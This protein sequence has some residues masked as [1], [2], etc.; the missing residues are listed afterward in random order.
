MQIKTKRLLTG[1]GCALVLVK[2]SVALAQSTEINHSNSVEPSVGSSVGTL[3]EVVV[4]GVRASLASALDLKRNRYE[5]VDSVVADDIT[6]LP[7]FS[8]TDA[9]QRVTGVQVARDRGDGAGLTIRGLTQMQTTLNGQEVFTAGPGRNFDFADMASEMLAGIDVYKTASAEHIEGGLSG[10]IDLRTRRP[11]D[12][13]GRETAASARSLY[14][15]LVGRNTTQFSMLASNRWKTVNGGEFGVLVNFAYQDRAF[16]EDQKVTGNPLS[17]SDLIAGQTVIAPNGTSETVSLGNRKRTTAEVMLQWRPKANLELYAGGSYTEFETRQNSYQV[18]ALASTSLVPG[19]LSLFPGTQDV[20]GV[21]WANAPVS[22][23]SFARDTLDRTKQITAG[24]IWTGKALTLKSDVNYTQSS[25]SLLFSGLTLGGT[26]TNLMQELSP[27]VPGTSISGANLADPAN[28][29]YAANAYRLR[30]FEGDQFSGRLDGEYELPG[31]WINT[32]LAGVRYARRGANNVAGLIFADTPLSGLAVATMPQFAQPNA[33]NFFPGTDS[34]RNT[35]IGNLDAARDTEAFRKALGITAAIPISANP[36]SLWD[37]SEETQAAYLMG[38]FTIDTETSSNTLD[39]N[40]GLRVVNTHERVAG[41]QSV[42]ATGTVAPIN[43]DSRYTDY[44]PSVNLRYQ[45]SPSLFLRAAAS[46]TLTRP[47]FDQL[48][49]SL[50]LLPNSVNPSLN[51]GGAGN[52]DLQPVRSNNLDVAIERYF[53]KS[54]AV[55]LTGFLKKVDGFVSTVSAPELVDGVTYQVSRPRNSDAA[56]VKGVELGYQQFYDFLPGW[57]RGLGLQA[58]YTYVDSATFD[59]SLHEEV[60]LQNLSKHSLNLIGMY[61]RGRLSARIAYNWRDKFLSGVTNLVGVGALP[62]YTRAYGWL[63]AS[64]SYRFNNAISLVIAGTNLLG[65][66]RSSYYG[67]ET[68]P[69]SSWT[70]DR[71]VSIA[72]S[73][74][75]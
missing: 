67:V 57:M 13:K 19:S 7:D 16:R 47:N 6:K 62:I 25:N 17:R 69:Q 31:G 63:D 66:V 24:G 42:P 15:D 32:V 30:R 65:T 45:L 51:Q 46:K 28:L 11:F 29:R 8:V 71:Q 35:L 44:L 74:R 56:D 36:L 54:T 1:Y 34:I 39:G 68:R 41:Y 26:A 43:I 27:S 23:L 14:G 64:V 58:N 21:T 61:E 40:V 52:P 60:A 73:A 9:L 18:N 4:I 50:T 72:V 59:R 48:S 33:Y 20:S 75:Y 10:L 38:R 53:N 2:A 49:P 55:H 22:I 12:F 3:G 37:I 5:I 70:N